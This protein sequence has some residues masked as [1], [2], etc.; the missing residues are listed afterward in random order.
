MD[1]YVIIGA[2]IVRYN[3]PEVKILVQTILNIKH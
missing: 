3:E 2:L 1:E